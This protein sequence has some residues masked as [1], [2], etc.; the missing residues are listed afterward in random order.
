MAIPE[1]ILQNFIR[2]HLREIPLD[3][4]CVS[5]PVLLKNALAEQH[6]CDMYARSMP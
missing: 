4:A 3:L 1:H 2:Q 5:S 6:V